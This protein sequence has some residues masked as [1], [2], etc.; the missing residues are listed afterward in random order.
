MGR[1]P[2]VAKATAAEQKAQAA[3][4]EPARVSA[5]REAARLWERAAE[6]EV[7]DKR[8]QEYEKNA[9]TAR[10]SAEPVE[11]VPAVAVPALRRVVM[12]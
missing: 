10:A 12:N 6:R 3:A 9:E 8:R 7:Q 11:V 4:D 2:F 1:N 5:W